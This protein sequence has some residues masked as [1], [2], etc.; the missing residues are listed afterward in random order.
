MVEQ[1]LAAE[2]ASGPDQ[3]VSLGIVEQ[4]A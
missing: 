1:Q 3:V 2:L 4:N